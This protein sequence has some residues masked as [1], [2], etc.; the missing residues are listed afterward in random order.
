ME[1]FTVDL[2]D[3]VLV[4]LRHRIARRRLPRPTPGAQWSAGTDPAELERLLAYW[5]DAFDWRS[6]ERRLNAVPQFTADI[7]GGRVHFAWIRAERRHPA[8]VPII[9]SHGWPYTFA[10]MLPIVPYLVDPEGHGGGPGDAFDVVVPSLPGFGFS[11]A[12][13]EARF[14]ANE[15]AERWHALMHDVLG[16]ERYA[17]YGEDVGTWI[18]DWTAALHP[19]SVLG[20]FATHAAFPS[21]ERRDDPTEEEIGFRARLDAKWLGESA[22]SELQSTKPDTLA[23][24]LNDS[25]AGLAAWLVEKFRTWSGGDDAYRAAWSDDDVL[26]TITL[27]WATRS[28]G[29]SFRAYFDDRFDTA[30]M[31]LVEVPV[32]VAVQYGERGF[33]QSWAAR[34]YRDIRAWQQLPSG[35]HFTVKQSPELVATAMREFFRPLRE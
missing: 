18:S 14:V 22:Y 34:T 13:G 8:P 25:P 29:T 11:E 31:P 20:L 9:L 19:E 1:P 23:A 26:T 21:A 12:P 10:E 2:A 16:Y 24:A 33:P 5:G 17:S 6:I 7:G 28:I 15:I 3:D 4:D 30:P 35:G 27:Y 32:G